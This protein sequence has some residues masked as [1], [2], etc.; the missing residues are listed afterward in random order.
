M[1]G[2]GR[3]LNQEFVTSQESNWIEDY[4]YRGPKIKITVVN[5]RVN[6]SHSQP[7]T[8]ILDDDEAGPSDHF[9]AGRRRGRVSESGYGAPSSKKQATLKERLVWSKQSDAF[10]SMKDRR[11]RKRGRN[12]SDEEGRDKR[13][14]DKFG[15]RD[16]RETVPTSRRWKDGRV[17]D[18]DGS[19]VTR[20]VR[21]SELRMRMRA[22]D[23]EE[24]AKHHTI[25]KPEYQ[26]ALDDDLETAYDWEYTR[27]WGNHS[28]YGPLPTGGQIRIPVLERLGVK[29]SPVRVRRAQAGAVGEGLPKFRGCDE[30]Q[31]NIETAE[32]EANNEDQEDEEDD[33]EAYVYNLIH[34]E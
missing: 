29:R 33:E 23:E 28:C 25:S 15:G 5:E 31:E 9:T 32:A 18:G 10:D 1:S 34:G 11:T 3:N 24:R 22:D 8:I 19:N 21:F 7:E 12:A 13:D 6:R 14:E 16:R 27:D 17:E 20:K 26:H 4:K 30:P 2:P